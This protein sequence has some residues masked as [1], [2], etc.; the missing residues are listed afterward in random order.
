MKKVLILTSGFY[1]GGTEVALNALLNHLDYSKY[2][3]DICCI[4]KRGPMLEKL[5]KE[6]HV[7]E[8]DFVAPRYRLYVSGVKEKLSSPKVFFQKVGKKIFGL[9]HPMKNGKNRFYNT[10]LK[11]ITTQPGKYDIILDFYGYGYFLT[12]YAAKLE[13]DKRAM[14]LH[15]ENLH[16]LYKVEEYLPEFDRIFCVSEAV[17][18]EFIKRC[19]GLKNKTEVFYNIVD[20]SEIKEKAEL[21]ID[22]ARYTGSFK[23]LTVGRL[24]YQKGYD[25][26]IQAAAIL[27]RQG[28][29][30]RWFVIG[31]GTELGKL[32]KQVERADVKEFV[33]LGR[34]ENPYSY[35]MHCD[36]YVQPSRHEGKALTIQEAKILNKPILVS[37]IPSNREQVTDGVNGYLVQA[38]PELLA[39]K[40][41]YLIH[42]VDARVRVVN[43]LKNEYDDFSSE[44]EKL[45]NL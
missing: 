21:P 19:P 14:W 36:L 4:C 1:G 7:K 2:A 3:V 18:Q 24:E 28:I 35:M 33:F 8:I 25:I 20:A 42:S 29:C 22:D 39:K 45:E 15:D 44:V 32:E 23:I 17:K 16:W 40:I 31:E 10:L 12:A 41:E 9:V 11:K 43:N 34:K 5:P 26:A 30:F 13:A 6:I 38:E 27:K 37:D